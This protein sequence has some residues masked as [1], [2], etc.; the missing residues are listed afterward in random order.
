MM[1]HTLLYICLMFFY[2][3]ITNILIIKHI[4]RF[5]DFL[6]LCFKMIISFVAVS[7]WHIYL[8]FIV[9]YLIRYNL[10]ASFGREP[11]RVGGYQIL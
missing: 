3:S 7:D 8:A 10:H 6:N 1:V 9:E 2:L 4:I 5:E 11:S